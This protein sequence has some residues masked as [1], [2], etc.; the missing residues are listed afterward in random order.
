MIF[1]IVCVI[2]KISFIDGLT[3]CACACMCVVYKYICTSM[4]LFCV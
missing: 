1:A 3:V 2:L 4:L